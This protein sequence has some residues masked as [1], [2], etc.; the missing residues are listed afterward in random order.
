MPPSAQ[1]AALV[2]EHVVA[3]LLKQARLEPLFA[4]F[5]SWSVDLD[6]AVLGIGDLRFRPDVLGSQSR[7]GACLW[8]WANPTLPAE[9][10]PSA[11]AVYRAGRERAVPELTH[12]QVETDLMDATVAGL[13]ASGLTGADAA[14]VGDA[15]EA[16]I[17]FLL[18]DEAVRAQRLPLEALGGI[19]EALGSS[20]YPLDPHRAF[21]ALGDRPPDGLTAEPAPDG[22]TLR[23]GPE[24]AR[25]VFD[26][27]G[28]VA[29]LDIHAGSG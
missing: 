16:G 18:R 1:L 5:D 27:A 2:E 4:G 22:F 12:A 13:V 9:H 6:A 23:A 25:V 10:A 21:R 3:S 14:W 15:G 20:G 8:A 26:D 17:A 19:L 11:K 29:E 24:S 28:R 7:N